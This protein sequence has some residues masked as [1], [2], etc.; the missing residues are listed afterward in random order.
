MVS[1]YKL[2][3]QV[4]DAVWD[5]ERHQLDKK[6]PNGTITRINWEDKEVIVTFT[7]GGWKDYDFDTLYGNWHAEKFGGTW[8]LHM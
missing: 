2:E 8:M 4:G 5:E 1:R 6:H 7:D 3:P